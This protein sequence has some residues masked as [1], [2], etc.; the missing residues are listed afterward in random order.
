VPFDARKVARSLSNK[1]FRRVENDHTFF[2][3]YVDGKDSG[4]FTK[5][6]HGEKE[7]GTPLAKRMQQQLRLQSTASFR[8]LVECPLTYEEY[9]KLLRDA[10][11]I[12]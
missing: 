11:V 7:I 12:D 10:G 4:V 6:S 2:H 9:V 3:L 1:G 5:I 8:D